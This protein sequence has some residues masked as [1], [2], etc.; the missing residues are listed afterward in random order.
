M[1]TRSWFQSGDLMSKEI[2]TRT[3]SPT[4]EQEKKVITLFGKSFTFPEQP[5]APSFTSLYRCFSEQLRS[6]FF[7]ETAAATAIAKRAYALHQTVFPRITDF[8]LTT[9]PPT[10]SQSLANG[11]NVLATVDAV[12]S[13]TVTLP[14]TDHSFNARLTDALVSLS[15]SL[16]RGVEGFPMLQIDV[17]GAELTHPNEV[18]ARFSVR[19]YTDLPSHPS[20]ISHSYLQTVLRAFLCDGIANALDPVIVTSSEIASKRTRTSIDTQRSSQYRTPL[21]MN[22]PVIFQDLF[23][24]FLFGNKMTLHDLVANVFVKVKGNQLFKAN[25]TVSQK[26]KAL[27]S[28][29][30]Y[31]VRLGLLRYDDQHYSPTPEGTRLFQTLRSNPL[32]PEEA[33]IFYTRAK[34][35]PVPATITK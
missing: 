10:I 13:H 2:K 17:K 22:D 29:L 20:D 24:A 25:T 12:L 28:I 5:H 33:L 23:E 34:C 6:E 3:D 11:E 21:Y 4:P 31:W 27:S 7:D 14:E 19:A 30:G 8:I 16:L 35:E 1:M 32:K 15:N 18:H 9:S 26:E